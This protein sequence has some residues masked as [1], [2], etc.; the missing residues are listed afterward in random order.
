VTGPRQ[1]GKITLCRATFPDKTYVSL[2][3]L[4]Q[5]EFARSEPRGYL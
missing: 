4:D 5:R 1:S 2:E 3:P